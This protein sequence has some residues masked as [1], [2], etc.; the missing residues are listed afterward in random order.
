MENLDPGMAQQLAQAAIALQHERTGH[1]PRSVDVVLSG[2][3]LLIAM[4]GVLSR[5]ERALAQSP[6]GAARFQEIHR[7]S[8][9][10]SVQHLR[11]EIKRITGLQVKEATAKGETRG[12]MVQAFTNGTVFLIFLLTRGGTSG[13]STGS[14]WSAA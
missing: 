3:I 11:Q 2:E 5:A 12:A 6:E 14:R 7:Q 4:H 10:H 9:S 13:T 1:A 8:F